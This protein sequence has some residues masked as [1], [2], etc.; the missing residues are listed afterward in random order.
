ASNLN[1]AAGATVANL[2][3][4]KLGAGGRLS[5]FN[6]A[7]WTDVIADVEGWYDDG[8][9]ADGAGYHPLTPARILDTRFGLGPLGPAATFDLQVTGQGGVPATGVSAV[10]LNVAVTGATMAGYLTAFPAGEALPPTSNLNFVAGQT[11]PNLVTAKLGAGGR[12]SLFNAAGSTDVIADVAGWYDDGAS[13]TGGRFHPVTPGRVLDT[14][15]GAGPLG[16]AATMGVQVAG[17]GGVPATGAT[18]VVLN[19]AVTGP[20]ASSYLTVFPGG[21]AMPVVSNLNFVA[22]QTVPNLVVAKLGAGGSLAAYNAAGTTDLVADVAGWF[23]A[24]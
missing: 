22:G 7:G 11:V 6:A 12:L 5:V 4:A 21:E 3:T 23:D 13:T 17:E 10:I 16:P 1:Y 24:G 20:T 8:T 9:V 18:A 19:V 14:R 15:F 2:V